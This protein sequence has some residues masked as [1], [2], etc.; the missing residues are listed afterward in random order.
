V[1]YGPSEY[2]MES[3]MGAA[4]SPEFMEQNW[5]KHFE[6]KLHKMTEEL[7]AILIQQ[8]CQTILLLYNK[9][10]LENPLAKLKQKD[11]F[12]TGSI[13][14]IYQKWLQQKHQDKNLT[15]MMHITC[16]SFIQ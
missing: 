4:C 16:I 6:L 7:V 13:C 8:K 5:N 2:G 14:S 9:S 1:A 3:F 10:K 11:A 12:L 15:L